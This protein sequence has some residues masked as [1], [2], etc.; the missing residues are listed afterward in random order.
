MVFV[1]FDWR[2]FKEYAETCRVGTIQIVKTTE[3]LEIRVL[4]GRFGFRRSF[5]MKDDGFYENQELY[6]EIN[7]FCKL[8]DFIPV[9]HSVPDEQFHT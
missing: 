6:D 5:K 7:E 9:E 1:T 4:T 2:G 3:G 8:H